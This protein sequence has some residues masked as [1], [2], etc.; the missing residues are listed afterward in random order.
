MLER[1]K[2]RNKPVKRW[3][4]KIYIWLT[5]LLYHQFAWAYDAVAW[6]VSFGHWH[7]WRLLALDF[8]KPGL[9]L[10]VGFGTGELLRAMAEQGINVIGLEKS[11]QMQR[12]FARKMRGKGEN[13][14]RV[15]SRVEIMPFSGQVFDNMISTFP[16]GYILKE[17]TLHE[18]YRVLKKNGR[19]VV[20]GMYV[21]LKPPVFKRLTH[22]YLDAGNESIVDDFLAK[23]KNA[24]LYVSI[25][26]HETKRYLLPIMILERS[27]DQ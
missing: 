17:K 16:S 24:G 7:K 22:W 9:C 8:L 5:E 4:S 10:E 25:I 27:D 23:A 26:F 19:M 11:T 3:I 13:I 15:Q 1:M 21:V 14:K 6:T 18:A 12:V 2:K 20:V